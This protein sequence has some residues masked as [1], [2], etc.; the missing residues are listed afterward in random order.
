MLRGKH[1][2]VGISGGIAAYKIPLLI[3]LLVTQGAEVKVCATGNA[4]RFVTPVTLETLSGNEVYTDVFAPHKEHS[5]EHVSLPDWADLMIVAP[6]TANI[7]GKMANGIADDALSTTFLAMNKPVLVAPAMNC[8]MLAHPAVRNNIATLRSWNHV[9]VLNCDEGFLACG[10]T[11]AG[12]MAEPEFILRQADKILE[13]QTLSG[14]K[15]LITA[16]PTQ[17]PI[18]PVRYISNHSTGKMAYALAEVCSKRGAEVT[19]VSG[20]MAS[21]IRQ[22]ATD[23]RIV[24]VTTAKQMHDAA[25]ELAPDNDIIILCAAVA[26]FTPAEYSGQKIKRKGDITLNLKPTNDIASRIGGN[27][28]NGQILVGFA[29]ETDHEVENARKKLESK[30]LDMIVLNSLQDNGAG[31]GYDTNKITLLTSA[32]ELSFPL[33]DKHQV[34]EDIT[35]AIEK[36]LHD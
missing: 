3:R 12:R 29:L 7:I 32:A 4:L 18:D 30:N 20:P 10:T 26:D 11:G 35:D 23:C 34:A 21:G 33:K 6:A 36:M 13:P 1:I 22:Q 24:D 19:V 2:L 27:K 15:I 8:N 28:H 5:T 17:E 16:G 31:F 9:T 25:I 14:K